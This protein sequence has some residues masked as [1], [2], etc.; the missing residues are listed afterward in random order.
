MRWN[1]SHGAGFR[2]AREKIE[3]STALQ[4]R[5][6]KVSN[7]SLPIFSPLQRPTM[8]WGTAKIHLEL[9]AKGDRGVANVELDIAV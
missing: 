5:I 6:G 3:A 2:F 9:K 1:A 8:G 7:V 4:T